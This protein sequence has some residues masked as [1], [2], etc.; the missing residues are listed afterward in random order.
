MASA[1]AGSLS[2]MDAGVP[3]KAHVAG[4]AM[5]LVTS[6]SAYKL[7]TDIQGPEDH[8][9]E[10]D[11]KVAGTK[12]GITAIQMDV[13]NKGIA[14]DIFG[15]ALDQARTARLH[16]LKQ[17]EGALES[18]RESVSPYAPTIRVLTIHPE[19]I[20]AVIG[21]GGRTIQG[22]IAA[23]GG[24]VTIDIEQDGTIFFAGT[25]PALVEQALH[26]VR[27]MVREFQVG[28]VLQGKV[29]RILDFGAIVDLGSGHDGMVHVSELKEGYVKRVEDV[30]HMGDA[31]T[32][33]VIRVD[34]DGKIALSMKKQEPDN[35]K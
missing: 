35:T 25:D 14:A 17:M 24:Q 28:E 31:V 15:A 22:I 19:K 10:M 18:P 23:T 32:V 16:I 26:T 9:G 29:V 27:E 5:G 1:C 8:H 3:L 6:G 34:H 20:G 30:V 11:L 2:L 4:I 33:Q 12:T 7:L 21:P 13:K